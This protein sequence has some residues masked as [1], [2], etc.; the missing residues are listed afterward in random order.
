MFVPERAERRS[1]IP[2]SYLWEVDL[3]LRKA[4]FFYAFT[5]NQHDDLQQGI[6]SS[7]QL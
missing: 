3:L 2:S 6:V 5:D 1:P 7:D 4:S